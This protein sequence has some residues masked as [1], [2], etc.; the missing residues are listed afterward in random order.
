MPKDFNPRDSFNL[1]KHGQVPAATSIRGLFHCYRM[2]YTDE[3]RYSSAMAIYWKE[4]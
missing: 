3:V 1:W 4:I 2:L